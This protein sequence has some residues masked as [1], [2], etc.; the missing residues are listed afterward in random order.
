MILRHEVEMHRLTEPRYNAEKGC[1]ASEKNAPGSKIN[2]MKVLNQRIL[3]KFS[4]ID[5]R[6]ICL[7]SVSLQF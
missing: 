2:C 1:R 6:V 7:L 4:R 5:G 3:W